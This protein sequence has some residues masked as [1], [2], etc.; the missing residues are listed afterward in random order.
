MPCS[1]QQPIPEVVVTFDDSKT[2]VEKIILG[3][4]NAEYPP[5]V[6]AEK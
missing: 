3:M 5:T 6:K 4:A 2:L 1:R